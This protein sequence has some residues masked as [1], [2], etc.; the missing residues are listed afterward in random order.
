MHESYIKDLLFIKKKIPKVRFRWVPSRNY[1]NQNYSCVKVSLDL[2]YKKR[3][4][5][6]FCVRFNYHLGI[7]RDLSYDVA[8][9]DIIA[10]FR[11][12]KNITRCFIN[13]IL[14]FFY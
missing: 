6:I 10:Q 1:L 7:R 12:P 13:I 8:N 9:L 4:N 2:S 11:M 5:V 3:Q 14:H